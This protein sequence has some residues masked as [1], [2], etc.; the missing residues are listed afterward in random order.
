VPV[1]RLEQT[2][3]PVVRLVALRVWVMCLLYL[4]AVVVVGVPALRCVAVRVVVMALSAVHKAL[5]Q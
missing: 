4:L 5:R 1:V 2:R 3:G